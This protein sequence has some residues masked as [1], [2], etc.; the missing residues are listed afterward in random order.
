[1]KNVIKIVLGIVIIV[2]I[3]LVYDS[4][5]GPMKEMAEVQKRE[6]A[7]IAQ[8]EKVRDAE[9]AFKD[10]KGSFSKDWDE[11]FELMKNGKFKVLI[12]EG[13]EDDSTSVVKMDSIFVSIKDSLFKNF[14]LDSLPFVPYGE[15]AQ[16]TLDAG[17]ITERNVTV[18]VFEAKDPKPYSK[19]RQ[20]ESNPLRVGSMFEGTY[21]GNW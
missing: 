18:Q 8:L 17:T 14:N 15:G 13:D 12:K 5:A 1:M 9:L 11:L 19:K 10:L 20:E 6:A 4:I 21:S 7:V 3:Y 16:F 2:L